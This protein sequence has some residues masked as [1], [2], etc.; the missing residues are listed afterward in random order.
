MYMNH[1]FD[2]RD[3]PFYNFNET[4]I[5]TNRARAMRRNSTVSVLERIVDI[6]YARIVCIFTEFCYTNDNK[7]AE[8][9]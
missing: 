9:G 4:N 2:Y 1:G 6:L 8:V 5:L 7:M 3:S